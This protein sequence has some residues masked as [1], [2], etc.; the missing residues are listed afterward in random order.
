MDFRAVDSLLAEVA[1]LLRS[2]S[3]RV[4]ENRHL[5]WVETHFDTSAVHD[6]GRDY[7]KRMSH[8]KF[9]DCDL[10]PLCFAHPLQ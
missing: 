6:L 5:P 7:S 4:R 9:A 3:L 2:L 10:G 1:F 8:D